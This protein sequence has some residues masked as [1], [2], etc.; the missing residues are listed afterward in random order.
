[1][2]SSLVIYPI[3]NIGQSQLRK[4]KTDEDEG[5]RPSSHD[6]KIALERK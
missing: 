4:K 3:V 6:G 1:V 5:Y 2:L